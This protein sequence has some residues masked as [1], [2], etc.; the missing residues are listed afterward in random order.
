[1]A[2]STEVKDAL[3]A[4]ADGNAARDAGAGEPVT[5]RAADRSR[6]R[7]QSET[8]TVPDQPAEYRTV[9]ERAS[10]A[11]D[12]IEAAATFVDEVG[13]AALEAAVVDAERELSGLAEEGRDALAAFERFRTAAD[14]SGGERP[15]G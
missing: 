1:M 5:G 11:T 3:A 12:D 6:T 14:G 15:H 10:S 9:I 4:L 7:E 13:I 2:D 8:G